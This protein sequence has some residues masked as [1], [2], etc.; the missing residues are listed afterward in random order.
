VNVNEYFRHLF[1]LKNF[2]MGIY[3][4]TLTGIPPWSKK[5]LS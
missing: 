2:V 4:L 3:A 5:S 1:S